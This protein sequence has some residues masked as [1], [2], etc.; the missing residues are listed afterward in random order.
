MA[1]ASYTCNE[2][3]GRQVP[4]ELLPHKALHGR[5]ICCGTSSVFISCGYVKSRLIN[6]RD[7]N[8]YDTILRK[9]INR[10]DSSKILHLFAGYVVDD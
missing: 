5:D 1:E 2:C 8:T 6:L 3:G 4:S 10:F 9:Y 7:I